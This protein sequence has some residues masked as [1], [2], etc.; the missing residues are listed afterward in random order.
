MVNLLYGYLDNN[1]LIIYF[2][3]CENQTFYQSLVTAFTVNN[4]PF[5]LSLSKGAVVVRQAHHER[6]DYPT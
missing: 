1:A 6:L 3:E 5:A 4:I 2:L